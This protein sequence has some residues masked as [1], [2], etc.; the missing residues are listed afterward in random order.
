MRSDRFYGRPKWFDTALLLGALTTTLVAGCSLKSPSA[1][2]WEVEYNLPLFN[3]WF[4]ITDLINEDEFIPFGADS[5][6]ALNFKQSLEKIEIGSDITLDDLNQSIS[7]TIGTFSVPAA[8]PQTTTI[9]FQKLGGPGSSG[10]FPV[11]IPALSF[12][13]ITQGLPLFDAFAQVVIDTG[14]VSVTVTNN[15]KVDFDTLNVRLLDAGAGNALIV[16]LNVTGTGILA[17]G[18]SL[19]VTEA[20]DGK[21]IG[22]DLTVEII[23]HTIAGTTIL[24]GTEGIDILV[25]VGEL[26]VSSATAEVGEIDF[27][28][29]PTISIT[30]ATAVESAVLSAGSLTLTVDNQLPIPLD[31]TIGLPNITDDTGTL[32]LL[33]P[34]ASAGAQGSAFRNLADHT[35]APDDDGSGGKELTLSVNVYSPGSSGAQVTLSS[36]DAVSIQ[37]AIS[38]LILE[39]ISGVLDSTSVTIPQ[40]SFEVASDNG[41]FL[42][43]A[44]KFNLTD[45]DLEL[46]IRHNIDFPADVQL[47]MIGEGGTPDPVQL[48]LAFHLD[49]SG[50]SPTGPA[51]TTM[52]SRVYTLTDMNESE[53]NLLQFLNAFPTTITSSGSASVGDGSYLGSISS[54]SS[55]Q[56]DLYFSTPLSF[57]VTEELVFEFDKEFNDKGFTSGGESAFEIQEATLTY[58]ISGTMG[59]PLTV[60]MM[61]ATD[62][63]QVYSNPDVELVLAIT[64]TSS[65]SQDTVITL[66]REQWELLQQP[67]YYGIRIVIPPTGGTPFRL[68][69]HDR[70]FMKAFATIKAI[71]DPGG[72][73]GGGDR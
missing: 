41:N 6:F 32:V 30:D 64:S 48:N 70:L 59:L 57:N 36:T 49:P 63:A 46:T 10:G 69:K 66:T 23:G 13:G 5:I 54:Y 2:S 14:S 22:N 21:T 19:S 43:E 9:S 25:T 11:P 51:D 17:D 7:Q 45:V 61:V 27:D 55:F 16:S 18:S 29:F 4:E 52:V 67:F 3:E 40:E 28:F 24:D 56:A 42:E 34:Q 53:A 65:A 12:S 20:L 60:G 8:P 73:G 35:L 38:G 58:A 62:S 50:F 68:A 33:N 26:R 31:L 37:A 15:T 72:K 47:N 1:P 39:S 71:I 44:R